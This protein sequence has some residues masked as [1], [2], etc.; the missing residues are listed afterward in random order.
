M[1]KIFKFLISILTIVFFI[2]LAFG[3]SDTDE[4]SESIN[5][6]NNTETSTNSDYEENNSSENGLERCSIHNIDY[7]SNTYTDYNGET[8][9]SG[10]PSCLNESVNEDLNEEGGFRD[11]VSHW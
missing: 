6:D 5:E 1:K 9:H 8:K 10:C 2:F 4:S 7:V 11:K 3:S